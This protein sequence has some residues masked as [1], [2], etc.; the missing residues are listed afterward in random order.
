MSGFSNVGTWA[1][2]YL[3]IPGT[4]QNSVKFF[5]LV[6]R[7]PLF[8]VLPR[9]RTN[10]PT[11]TR[12]ESPA[13]G[14]SLLKTASLPLKTSQRPY[15]AMNHLNQPSIFG[16]EKI[17]SFFWRVKGRLRLE[18]ECFLLGPFAYFVWYLY[19]LNYY[20]FTIKKTTIHVDKHWQIYHPWILPMGHVWKK[21]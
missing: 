6:Y 14:A 18:C 10:S 19:L 20:Q 4:I 5:M 21:T 7:L 9:S 12:P 1:L 13:S 17:I 15:K 8:P 2:W 3:V 16:G 11:V